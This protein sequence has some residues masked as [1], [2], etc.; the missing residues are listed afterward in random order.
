MTRKDYVLIA[1]VIKG[2]IDT[3]GV[4]SVKRD[5]AAQV[6]YGLADTFKAENRAFDRKRFVEACGLTYRSG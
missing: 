3:F 1:K 5:G 2:E 6:V 4:S